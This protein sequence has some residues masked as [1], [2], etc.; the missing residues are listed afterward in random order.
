MKRRFENTTSQRFWE[1]HVT[2]DGPLY[3]TA[4]P[5]GEPG[6][7]D[8][9]DLDD[10]PG[11][12]SVVL[13]EL[14][15]SLPEGYEEVILGGLLEEVETAHGV[16]LSGRLRDFYTNEEYRKHQRKTCPEYDCQVDFLAPVV[17]FEFDQEYYDRQA[18]R[19][20]QLIPI[21]SKWTGAAY[22]YED[23]Q[24][25]FGVDPTLPDGPVYSLYTSGEYAIAYPNIDAFLASLA[26]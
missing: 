4:G 5:L 22:G 24:Q 15:Q 1:L 17:Q 23:E 13:S 3:I 6:T 10:A 20:I 2:S 18:R 9:H 7:T 21:A 19:H 25:W 16:T 11:P 26:A 8:E 14:L 12:P